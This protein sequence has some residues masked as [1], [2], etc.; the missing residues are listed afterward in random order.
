MSDAIMAFF[1][2]VG[3]IPKE[4]I[5]FITAM[6]PVTELRVALPWALVSGVNT[7]AAYPIAVL[8]NMVPVPFIILFIRPVLNW[9]KTKKAFKKLVD[10]V[11]RK[12]D[13]GKEK[14]LKYEKW[15]LFLFVAI[16]LPGTG[17][18]TGALIAAMLNMRLKDA[19]PS[20]LAGVAGAGLIMLVLTKGITGIFA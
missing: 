8:G 16:P 13:S 3:N 15:G 19:V 10:F 6:I 1:E 20:I 2:G 18:W 5:L 7:F 17:A 12:A 11:E 14:V 9:L 4:W